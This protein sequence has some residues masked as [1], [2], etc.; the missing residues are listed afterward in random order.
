MRLSEH[1]SEEEYRCKCCGKL[2]PLLRNGQIPDIYRLFFEDFEDIRQ[3]YGLPIIINSGYRCIKHNTEIGG[4]PTSIHVFG[5]A[6]DCT[7][8]NGNQIDDL[9]NIILAIHPELRIGF[10]TNQKF[11]HIDC[12]YNIIPI[13]DEAWRKGA[14][15]F[16]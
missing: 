6:L 3:E 15:W 1:I 7:T 10:Y 9:H 5:L 11:I 12:G 13:A 2:P 16:K 4:E 8:Q 14:R